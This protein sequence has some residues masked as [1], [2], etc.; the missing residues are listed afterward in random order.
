LETAVR[1]TVDETSTDAEHA[2]LPSVDNNDN[3]LSIFL[4]E[5]ETNRGSV[6][7]AVGRPLA[8]QDRESSAQFVSLT[9]NASNDRATEIVNH[10]K[11]AL[12]ALDVARDLTKAVDD[13]FAALKR[14]DQEVKD[15]ALHLESARQ[16]ILVGTAQAD[17]VVRLIASFEPRLGDLREQEHG[18]RSLESVVAAFEAREQTVTG[19]LDR[20][21]VAGEAR[22]ELL[23]ETL[24]Q[25]QRRTADTISDLEGRV[26]DC[27]ARAHSAEETIAHVQDVSTQTLPELRERLKEADEKHHAIEQTITEAVDIATSFA[28]LEQRLPRVGQC[29]QELA[30]LELV[31]PQ[32]ER[33]LEDINES[34]AHQIRALAV[35]EQRVQRTLDEAQKS[36]AVASTLEN[37]IAD[38]SRSHQQLDGVEQRVGQ[39]EARA[40]SAAGEFTQATRAKTDLEQEV[41]ALQNQLRRLKETTDDDAQTLLELRQQ[42]ERYQDEQA[43]K[44]SAIVSGLEGRLADI[45]SGHQQLDGVEQQIGQLEQRAAA[46][47]TEVQQAARAKNDLE[48]DVVELQNRLR[49]MTETADNEAKR[50]VELRQHAERHRDE[51]AQKTSAVLSGLEARM[52]DVNSGHQLLDGVEQ[53]LQQLGARTTAAATEV[54]LAAGAKSGLEREVVDLQNQLR[55]MTETAEDEAKRL[56]EIQQRAKRYQHEQSQDASATLSVLETRMAD[57]GRTHKQLHRVDKQVR[58]LEQRAAA[59]A[60]EVRQATLARNVLQHEIAELQSQLRR[61]MKDAQDETKKLAELN[62]QAN[63][64]ARATH[65]GQSSNRLLAGGVAVALSLVVVVLLG[66]VRRFSR[67]EN[68]N[69]G[70]PPAPPLLASRTL[71]YPPLEAVAL[72]TPAT[73][74]SRSDG[75][76]ENRPTFGAP[77]ANAQVV[78]SRT[79][80]GTSGSETPTARQQAAGTGLGLPQSAGT[81]VIESNPPGGRAFVNQQSVGDTPVSLK[82]LR[83]GSYVVR[84]EHEGY[85]RWS[86]AVTVSTFREAH[87]TATLQRDAAR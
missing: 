24:E 40:A 37:R 53:Q 27:E 7:G 46:A 61:M 80:A 22:R 57:I 1:V 51:Q 23:V 78:L 66:G 50:L 35:C 10:L 32:V 4:P 15:R 70:N 34:I 25:L 43:Q 74:N 17:D 52:A 28:A 75:P 62:R 33:R 56:G 87:V 26:G 65:G 2:G 39:L 81:L 14:L 59:A 11:R 67:A 21:L 84:V 63:R 29:D 30:R 86:T 19:D 48:Q 5:I 54:K 16:D 77:A 49:L 64:H 13:R 9:S 71:A 68:G 36:A 82:G 41:G 38:L 73:I 58:Q 69:T 79:A 18:L 60:T 3:A 55:R 20:H 42:A 8:A 47:A 85:Q 72:L 31:V 45:G 44:T 6:D 76:T 12:G 83:A